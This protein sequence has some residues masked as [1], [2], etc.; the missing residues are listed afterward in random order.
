MFQTTGIQAVIAKLGCECPEL[1]LAKI[2]EP[3]GEAPS[4]R[5]VLTLHIP[6]KGGSKIRAEVED[7]ICPSL[8]D[9]EAYLDEQEDEKPGSFKQVVTRKGW[10][11]YRLHLFALPESERTPGLPALLTMACSLRGKPTVHWHKGLPPILRIDLRG[12]LEDGNGDPLADGEKRVHVHSKVWMDL[13]VLQTTL[14]GLT[15]EE[16]D[17][18]DREFGCVDDG[19]G[20]GREF[21]DGDNGVDPPD[22]LESTTAD[23]KVL[24]LHAFSGPKL[25]VAAEKMELVRPGFTWQAIQLYRR[26]TGSKDAIRLAWTDL[27]QAAQQLDVAADLS[28]VRK[29]D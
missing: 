4:I 24:P 20:P 26:R 11:D 12:A 3:P 14:D 13:E 9:N 17:G 23:G 2:M 22:D 27:E 5:D 15:D 8:T 10:G 19:D 25:K 18:L 7:R 1:S 21:D 28:A 6:L 16:K 29:E